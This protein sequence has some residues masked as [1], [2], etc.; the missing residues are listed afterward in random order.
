[1]KL[2]KQALPMSRTLYVPTAR[3]YQPRLLGKPQYTEAFDAMIRGLATV[4]GGVTI[5][6]GKGV[7][8]SDNQ[9][10]SAHFA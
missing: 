10:I 4:C 7:W 1:M 8:L 6:S 5:T 9:N 2:N 3:A